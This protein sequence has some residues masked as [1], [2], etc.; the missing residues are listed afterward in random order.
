MILASRD[1]RNAPLN[2]AWPADAPPPVGCTVGGGQGAHQADA[3]ERIVWV[4]PRMRPSGPG[5]YFRS[6]PLNP[7]WG[8]IIRPC[9]AQARKNE[10]GIPG[11]RSGKTTDAPAL[12]TLR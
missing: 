12:M 6:H 2:A 7:S 8:D 1:D 4:S 3:G 5:D 10:V 9:E 11:P